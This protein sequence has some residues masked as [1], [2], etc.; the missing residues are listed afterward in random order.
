MFLRGNNIPLAI[1]EI[2]PL[3]HLVDNSAK[4]RWENRLGVIRCTTS[5]VS[6]LV[7]RAV[8]LSESGKL[9]LAN[10]RP[11]LI[12]ENLDSISLHGSDSSEIQFA[13]KVRDMDSILKSWN[14]M[15]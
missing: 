14:W 15:K 9:I 5:P 2:E 6:F 13:V 3:T 12:V 11:S 1:A 10:E 7:D 8:L 4:I